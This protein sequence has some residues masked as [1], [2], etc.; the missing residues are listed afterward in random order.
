MMYEPFKSTSFL[1]RE[2]L[3]KIDKTRASLII[4]IPKE[5]QIVEKRLALTPETTALLWRQGIVY[6]LK[7]SGTDDQLFGSILCRVWG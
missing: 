4:G 2:M 1:V 3:Q 5:N 6:S 7:K